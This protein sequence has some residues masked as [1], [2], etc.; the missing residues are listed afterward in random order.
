MLRCHVL[1]R[2]STERL[3]CA[4]ANAACGHAYMCVHRC[5]RRGEERRGEERKREERRG[6]EKRG[7]FL[8]FYIFKL[9]E[10]LATITWHS[11]WS[12]YVQSHLRSSFQNY[13]TGTTGVTTWYKTKQKQTQ[14]HTHTHHQA[15]IN[16]FKRPEILCVSWLNVVKQ[17]KFYC[18]HT[19]KY[20]TNQLLSSYLF[21][22]C[23]WFSKTL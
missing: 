7:G 16:A 9:S 10:V 8:H 18:K 19:L 3:L 15:D 12:R 22:R 1:Y 23:N 4:S 11:F 20:I 17:S 13:N 6:E 21:L 5:K 14:T 2:D